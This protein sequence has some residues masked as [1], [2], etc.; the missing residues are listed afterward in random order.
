MKNIASRPLF[1]TLFLSFL[2]VLVIPCLAF[3]SFYTLRGEQYVYKTLQSQGELLLEQDKNELDDIIEGYIEKADAIK[4]DFNIIRALSKEDVHPQTVYNT[5]FNI[6]QKDT[7]NAAAHIESLDGKIKYSTHTFPKMYDLR[8]F[9]NTWE[10]SNVLSQINLS[11]ENETYFTILNSSLELENQILISIA[12]IIKTDDE[13]IGV[14]IIDIFHEAINNRINTSSIFSEELLMDMRAYRGSSLIHANKTGSYSS[15]PQL[16]KNKTVLSSH[17]NFPQLE[18]IAYPSTEPFEIVFKDIYRVVTIIS[19]SAVIVAIFISL[20][21]THNINAPLKTL[22]KAMEKAQEGDLSIRYADGNISDF[23]ELGNAFNRML[24]QISKLMKLNQE[25]EA[26]LM[27]AERKALESQLNPHFLFNT[28]NTI[29]AIAR[30]NGQK[31]IYTITLKLAS[32]LR[33]SIT[34]NESECTIAQSLEMAEDYLTIQKLRFGEKLQFKID[35]EKKCEYLV[36]PRLIIQPLIEN[37]IIHGL[38]EKPGLWMV[39]IKIFR[40][41][42]QHL[43]IVVSDNGVGIKEGVIPKD[44]EDLRTTRHVGLYNVYRRLRIRYKK[45]MGFD[46]NSSPGEGTTV[47]ITLPVKKD[48]K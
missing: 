2:L 17:L 39:E 21:L 24:G 1:V 31:E 13:E 12:K 7:Y 20:L 33:Y 26:K 45:D 46:I 44:L 38:E 18:L 29:K 16:D 9:N 22:R 19:L 10:S 41:D 34:H 15:F 32:L 23:N 48:R 36:T 8:I 47:K 3:L 28:L 4:N 25:E 11:D 40:D 6:M 30:L 5:L 42:E 14:V 37:S 35:C 43:I 27:E